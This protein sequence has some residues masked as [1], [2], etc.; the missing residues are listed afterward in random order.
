M[1]NLLIFSFL[2]VAFSFQSALSL[3]DLKNREG[4]LSGQEKLISNILYAGQFIFQWLS[5]LIFTLEYLS[6]EQEVRK[7]LGMKATKNKREIFALFGIIFLVLAV[8]FT[9]LI[10][11]W[12]GESFWDSW[13]SSLGEAAVAGVLLIMQGRFIQQISALIQ[14]ADLDLVPVTRTFCANLSCVGFIFLVQCGDVTLH[15]ITN[16]FLNKTKKEQEDANSTMF[17]IL[18]I[19]IS[20]CLLIAYFS[21][22]LIIFRSTKAGR[23]FD[24]LILHENVPELVYLQTRKLLRNTHFEKAERHRHDYWDTDSISEAKVRNNYSLL[25]STGKSYRQQ[26]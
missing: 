19:A 22:F 23:S 7:V 11:R 10:C 25:S 3:Y 16:I 8:I 17:L 24:D 9:Y 14:E 13:A 18:A 1:T 20:V 21:F 4:K 26:L 12:S 2:I 6:T 15:L 5:L